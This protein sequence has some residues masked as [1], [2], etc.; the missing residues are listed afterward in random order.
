MCNMSAFSV[1]R[2]YQP[3]VQ[4]LATYVCGG[5]AANIIKYSGGNTKFPT[6]YS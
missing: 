2:D 5:V 1:K 4:R 3:F 6:L